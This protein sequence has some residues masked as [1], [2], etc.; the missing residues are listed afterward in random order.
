MRTT[1]KYITVIL[2]F[3]QDT[4]I[5]S[6]LSEWKENRIL[7][8]RRLT[9]KDNLDKM[10]EWVNLKHPVATFSYVSTPAADS[11]GFTSHTSQF[12]VR[13]QEKVLAINSRSCSLSTNDRGE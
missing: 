3:D 11:F 13:C 12:T 9:M 6:R 10:F 5:Y 7:Q 2:A 8:R 4:W 1:S